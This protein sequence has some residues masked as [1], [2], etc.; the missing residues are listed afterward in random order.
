[1]N[2]GL[3]S[4]PLIVAQIYNVDEAY[5]PNVEIFFAVNAIAGLGSGYWLNYVDRTEND[6][7][8]N[9]VYHRHSN[10]SDV[11][12][13]EQDNQDGEF[14]QSTGLLTW[15]VKWNADV[16]LEISSNAQS[17]EVEQNSSILLL[18]A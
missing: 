10:D 5:I 15:G 16:S 17:L 8:L 2:I 11:A 18:E 4:Y 1:M 12:V 6:G 3:S 7:K 13:S 14:Q 9:K